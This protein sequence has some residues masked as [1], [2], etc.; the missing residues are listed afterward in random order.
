MFTLEDIKAAHSKVKSGADFPRY[1]KDMAALGVA[2]YDH[3]VSDGHTT[4]YGEGVYSLSSPS[5]WDAKSIADNSSTEALTIVLKAHQA[6]QTDYLTFCQ[7][8]ADSG[9]DKWTVDM[10]GMTCIYYDKQGNEM[11]K[12][13]IPT[14]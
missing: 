14:K 1:A 8:A 9:V 12:E 4:Y 7:Q 11:L 6:G 3:H 10:I 13:T 5:K 2:R